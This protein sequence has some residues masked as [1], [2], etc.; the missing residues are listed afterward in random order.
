MT[1]TGAEYV[2]SL[3]DGREVWIDGERVEDVTTHPA[4]RNT[5]RSIAHLYDMTH[6][7]RYAD[8]L[9][10]PSPA[11]GEPVHRAYTIPRSQADL[12]ARRRATKTWAEATFGYLG[13]SPDYMASCWAGFAAAPGLFARGGQERADN[14]LAYYAHLRDDDLYQSHTI[15]NPQIDRSKPAAEQEEP[16]LY[17]GVVAERD[18][19][20]VVRGAKMVGTAALFGDEIF[21]GTIEPLGRDDEDYALTFSI[22][23]NTPG[24]KVISRASYEA[25]ARSPW[26]NPLSSRFDENDALMIYEN[27]FVPW[28]RVFV[29]RDVEL[30]YLQWWDTPA[31]AY[32]IHQAATRYWTKL[33]FLAGLAIKVAKANNVLG[34]P[35]V[36]MQLG[37]VLSAVNLAQAAVL[38]MEAGCEPVPG[39]DG[40]VMPNRAIAFA[41]RAWAPRTYFE[42]LEEIKTL[43]GGSLI[44]MPASY[45][46]L[47][48]P[49]VGPLIERY[50]RSP[51][52]TAEERIKLYKLVWDAVGS[53][54]AS[55]HEHY[56]R[57]YHGAPYVYLPA[58][59]RMG[60][61]DACEALADAALS[62]YELADVLGAD[63]GAPLAPLARAT[64]S[65]ER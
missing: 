41:Q 55:R 45:R 50:V 35:L 21:V 16:F 48:H 42:L 32:W 57:F 7:P 30:A 29:Y 39:G 28:E 10:C 15:V 36:R 20:I 8:V 51:G 43:A 27:V 11:T 14:L 2:E 22:P 63:D 53:E 19:G 12:V 26:D 40:A 64:S 33:E 3:R 31:F 49:E 54:F 47:V 6:D 62:G 5:V 44:Q 65:P 18:D 25:A 23:F 17:V 46:D 13:R 1:R 60:K 38:A 9:T 58:A 52:H 56:E 24:V 37:R 61:P 4:F 59:L 34:M